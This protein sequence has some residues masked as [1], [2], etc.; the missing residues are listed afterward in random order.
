VWW[1]TLLVGCGDGAHH[2]AFGGDA[3]LG[4]GL[5]AAIR[6]PARAAAMFRDAP[7]I[8]RRADLTLINAEGVAAA[9]GDF[10]FKGE[11]RPILYR[12]DPAV[13][14]LLADAGVD[15]VNLANNHSFDYGPDALHEAL[16]VFAAAGVGTVG[17][18]LD[19]EGARR[20]H[21]RVVG[22]TTVAFVGAD[23][24]HQPHARAGE[25]APGIVTG[26]PAEAVELLR[27]PIAVAREH[28]DLVFLTVHWG[29]G[30]A[31]EPVPEVRAA[32]A[33][34]MELGVDAIL[35][36]SAHV[37]QGVELFDGRPVVYDAGN[38]LIPKPG[39]VVMG[40][41]VLY[42]LSFTK[43]GVTSVRAH[44]I[45]LPGPRVTQ[46]ELLQPWVDRTRALG[47]AVDGDTVTCDPGPVTPA[48]SPPPAAPP[49]E[50]F[51]A[52]QR[53]VVPAV[54]PWATPADVAFTNGMTLV[55]WALAADR[56]HAPKGSQ[57]A[58]LWFRIDRPQTADLRVTVHA[59]GAGHDEDVHSPGD[60]AL[61]GEELVPGTILHDRV[62]VRLTQ[63][64][65]GEVAFS[66]GLSGA[67]GEYPAVGLPGPRAP[68]ATA[69]FDRAAPWVTAMVPP[70]W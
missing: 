25:A 68:L 16:S 37:I 4:E 42:D 26:E 24:T 23:L 48:S 47:T 14:R 54:A 5:N 66:V 35:G 11:P 30:R 20:P 12:A 6:D 3:C 7:P 29:P 67:D 44:P 43:A 32:A 56:I 70:P 33:A 60:W 1:S 15:V 10:G 38:F 22:D 52:P 13:A 69:V 19:A 31:T 53:F 28:A 27:G 65:E 59:D 57:I 9:G 39:E 18:G 62:L 34:L 50:P 45:H 55:G 64:N 61:S 2:L 17:A 46:G 8:L 51:A 41:G 21:Y 58:H 36:H 63:P 49:V 40:D